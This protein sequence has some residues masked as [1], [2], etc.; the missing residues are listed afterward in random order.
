MWNNATA[1]LYPSKSTTLNVAGRL[2]LPHAPKHL[3][4]GYLPARHLPHW[5]P[6]VKH[7]WGSMLENV[8]SAH[9]LSIVFS[10]IVPLALA[11]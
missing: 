6:R 10:Q 8:V 3:P 2:P 9:R 11:T 5:K 4:S 7:C 1:M